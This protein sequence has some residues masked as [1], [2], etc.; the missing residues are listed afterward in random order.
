MNSKHWIK[1]RFFDVED[2]E[3]FATTTTYKCNEWLDKSDIDKMEYMKKHNPRRYQ[4]AGLGQW[5]IIDGLVYENWIEKEFDWREI[6]KRQ[7]I[8]V[9]FGLDFGYTNDPTAFFVGL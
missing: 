7:D 6:L 2:S 8:K 4:V 1:K 3:I 9:V 5:G